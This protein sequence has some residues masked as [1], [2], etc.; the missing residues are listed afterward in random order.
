MRTLIRRLALLVL[1]VIAVNPPVR[2]AELQS[3]VDYPDPIVVS[4]GDS[5]TTSYGPNAAP[6]IVSGSISGDDD[7]V[8]TIQNSGG[9]AVNLRGDNSG[10]LGSV[11]LT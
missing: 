2:A 9:G 10:F 7:A 4:G 11:A 5:L 3:G 1:A 8:L 6:A